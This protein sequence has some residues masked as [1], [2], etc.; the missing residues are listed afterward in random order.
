MFEIRKI[1]LD[2]WS[3]PSNDYKVERTHRNQEVHGGSA[4]KDVAVISAFDGTPRAER[5]KQ[6]FKESYGVDFERHT[7]TRDTPY[8]VGSKCQ[9]LYELSRV[10]GIRYDEAHSEKCA[11]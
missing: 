7:I 8:K 2:D 11:R 3:E 6:A 10:G 4:A 9:I 5:W 1:T